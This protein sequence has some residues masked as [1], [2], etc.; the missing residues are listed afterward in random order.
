MFPVGGPFRLPLRG[1]FPVE[2]GEWVMED[3]FSIL[4]G[5]LPAMASGQL[6]QVQAQSEVNQVGIQVT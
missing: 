3:S 6:E 2:M 5:P 1:R 4:T